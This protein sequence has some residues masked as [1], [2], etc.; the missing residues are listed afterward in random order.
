MPQNKLITFLVYLKPL[1]LSSLGTQRGARRR[2][3]GGERKGGRNKMNMV[4]FISLTARRFYKL[5]VKCI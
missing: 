5:L 3:E 4:S 2:K 1:L